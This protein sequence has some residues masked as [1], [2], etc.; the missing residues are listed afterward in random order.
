MSN[1]IIGATDGSFKPIVSSSSNKKFKASCGYTYI[2][3]HR[4][5]TKVYDLSNFDEFLKI[6]K[7]T[8]VGLNSNHMTSVVAEYLG[9]VLFFRDIVLSSEYT[10]N[11]ISLFTDHNNFITIYKY[12]RDIDNISDQAF[13]KKKY[14]HSRLLLEIREWMVHRE[15]WPECYHINSHISQFKLGINYSD[16][17]TSIG[18]KPVINQ[19]SSQFLEEF[20]VTWNA[21][22]TY[23]E[24]I[25]PDATYESIFYFV[26][27]TRKGLYHMGSL[28]NYVI[29]RLL[30]LDGNITEHTI[31]NTFQ[32]GAKDVDPV[33]FLPLINKIG[34]TR[35]D[36]SKATQ[37][38]TGKVM[39]DIIDT[40]ALKEANKDKICFLTA[41]T[42]TGKS[43]S[44][45]HYLYLAHGGRIC[46]KVFLPRI[47]HC[48]SLANYF[49]TGD[50]FGNTYKMGVNVG[51]VT[52][53]Y[54]T[55]TKERYGITFYTNT[56]L[57]PFLKDKKSVPLAN[58]LIIIDEVQAITESTEVTECFS[59]MAQDDS[60]NL[61]DTIGCIFMSATAD[62]E[63]M[64]HHL[65]LPTDSK[66]ILQLRAK[67]HK[68][69][70]TTIKTAQ[71]DTWDNIISH[72]DSKGHRHIIVFGMGNSSIAKMASNKSSSNQQDSD[73]FEVIKVNRKYI[74]KHKEFVAE[75]SVKNNKVMYVATQVLESSVTLPHVTAVYDNGFTN[76][77]IILPGINLY[78]LV[79]TPEPASASIQRRGR[80]GRTGPGEYISVYDIEHPLMESMMEYRDKA[81]WKRALC[82]EPL[83]GDYELGCSNVFGC[84][85]EFALNMILNPTN[86]QYQVPELNTFHT[87]KTLFNYLK[88]D[89]LDPSKIEEIKMSLN[90]HN[91]NLN[92]YIYFLWM[93]TCGLSRQLSTMV[94][95]HMTLMEDSAQYATSWC[96][97]VRDCNYT[98]TNTIELIQKILIE[99]KDSFKTLREKKHDLHLVYSRAGLLDLTI[100]YLII[101][102]TISL[103]KINPESNAN[104]N[105]CIKLLSE[106][107]GVISKG[108]VNST[109]TN[110]KNQT[111]FNIS[112]INGLFITESSYP[113]DKLKDSKEFF[114]YSGTLLASY[115]KESGMMPALIW[116]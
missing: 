66:N 6:N 77:M 44:F 20:R 1:I 35:I 52:G 59:S 99:D 70:S 85:S 71:K 3:K 22:N 48:S 33:T 104:I 47:G 88:L 80:V 7:L 37:K 19:N 58:S 82:F 49:A 28:L 89:K 107:K 8:H 23:D 84:T 50:I 27:S 83:D 75:E 108:V 67:G 90:Q 92:A 79:V 15:I 38:Y 13:M 112:L 76:T 31:K 94:A 55:Y 4:W 29:D 5:V 116:N 95:A 2:D 106:F 74:D 16:I 68:I 73:E 11:N 56:L 14:E 36:T 105:K 64:C 113:F 63:H 43:T 115:S 97:F 93:Y 12:L 65:R 110:S 25:Y 103:I 9:I 57:I 54:S 100:K 86:R 24:H 102:K 62:L 17:L 114:Y 109:H 69:E 96:Q 91:I 61:Q 60:N 21:I 26:C 51:F 18:K 41:P 81:E 34:R 42:G 39:K 53:S 46:I 87:Y 40:M 111:A 10:E 30:E 98:N 72:A 45:I 101:N 78:S 32:G